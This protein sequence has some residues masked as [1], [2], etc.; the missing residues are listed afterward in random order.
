MDDMEE[1]LAWLD[2]A[3]Y[4]GKKVLVHCRH[5][6]GRTGTFITAYLLRR[7]FNL[8]K[9]GKLL[10]KTETRANP[11]NF[12]QWWLLRKFGKKQGQLTIDDPDPQNRRHGELEPF[13]SRYELLLDAIDRTAP[14]ATYQLS[15]NQKCCDRQNVEVHL[16]EALY[17][18]TRANR[19]LTAKKRQELTERE[20]DPD[21]SCLLLLGTESPL[22]PFRPAGCRLYEKTLPV[23]FAMRIEK[24]LAQLSREVFS[25]VFSIR[26]DT[27]PPPVQIS[28]VIS[29]RFI[30]KYFQ[31][32]ANRNSTHHRP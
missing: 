7:G 23:E 21:A 27:T 18:H 11:T 6:I 17:L 25:E 29:G 22:F 8:K 9:A 20:T 10:K 12:S 31:L 26:T 24:E 28:D 16:I 32:L 19:T 3:I 14:K 15:D 4:L 2:E 13:F 30:Q 5:G 1:G